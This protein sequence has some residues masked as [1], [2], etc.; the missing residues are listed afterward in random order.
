MMPPR[1]KRKPFINWLANPLAYKIAHN[2]KFENLWSS[3]KL[4]QP[5]NGWIWDSMLFAHIE[6]N[7]QG[8]T[9][10]KFQVYVNFGII[11]YDSEIA[12]YLDSKSKDGNAF[13]RIKELIK[14][15][16]GKEKLLTYCGLDALYGHKLAMRQMAKLTETC[17]KAKIE[18]RNKIM[19]GLQE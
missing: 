4:K 2:L 15:R 5:V 11:D 16:E 8:I 18:L 6:D 17:A 7:R 13:N 14:T 1:R 19:G 3:I 9:G 12:P 10:L